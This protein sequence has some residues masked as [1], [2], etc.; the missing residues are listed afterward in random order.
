MNAA[1]RRQGPA[2]LRGALH[3]TLQ[4]ALG[5]DLAE[6][7]LVQSAILIALALTFADRSS[8]IAT[9]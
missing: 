4:T 5:P 8:R 3:Q 9:A 7:L 6:L 1:L 2:W